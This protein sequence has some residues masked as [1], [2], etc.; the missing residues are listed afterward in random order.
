ML[1]LPGPMGPFK[2]VENIIG[3]K[4]LGPFGNF[5]TAFLCSG[6][7]VQSSRKQSLLGPFVNIDTGFAYFDGPIQIDRNHSWEKTTGLI[8]EHRC[9]L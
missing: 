2:A 9:S 8:R 5:D 1:A 4:L 3:K 7:P 6:G